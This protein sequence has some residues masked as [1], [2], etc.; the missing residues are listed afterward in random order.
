MRRAQLGRSRP[1]AS[2]VHVDDRSFGRVGVITLGDQDRATLSAA[3]LAMGIVA[4]SQSLRAQE[5]RAPS[6]FVQ[7]LGTR[8]WSSGRDITELPRGSAIHSPTTTLSKN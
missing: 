5:V 6:R 8:V 1:R 2:L 4:A 3:N 7:H